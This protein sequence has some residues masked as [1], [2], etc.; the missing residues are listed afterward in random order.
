MV[1]A[2]LALTHALVLVKKMVSMFSFKYFLKYF[3]KKSVVDSNAGARNSLKKC[4]QMSQPNAIDAQMKTTVPTQ[5]RLH[6]MLQGTL[7][8][9]VRTVSYHAINSAAIAPTC[10]MGK[11]TN[12]P[13]QLKILGVSC[14]LA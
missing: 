12:Q 14:C 8:V 13:P 9:H 6:H 11:Q 10:T 2:G 3:P 5:S 1:H 4:D 7:K